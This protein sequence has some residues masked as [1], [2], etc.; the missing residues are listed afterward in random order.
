MGE[1]TNYH[2]LIYSLILLKNEFHRITKD[3]YK[4]L[5]EVLNQYE[6]VPNDDNDHLPS[7][8]CVQSAK[9]GIRID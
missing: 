3:K 5:I 1:Q 6:I 2:N 4:S 7:H 8:H 9:P